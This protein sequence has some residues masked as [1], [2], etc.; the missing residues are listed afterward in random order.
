M[1]Q[2]PG[3]GRARLWVRVTVRVTGTPATSGTGCRPPSSGVPP[4]AA[5][6]SR[7]GSGAAPTWPFLLRSAGM[8]APGGFRSAAAAEPLLRPVLAAEATSWGLGSPRGGD[9]WDQP[10]PQ[11]GLAARGM[12]EMR[13]ALSALPG[14]RRPWDTGQVLG[15]HATFRRHLGSPGDMGAREDGGSLGAAETCPPHGGTTTTQTGPSNYF[16]HW[17]R[18][19]PRKQGPWF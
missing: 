5:G 2:R 15:A 12:A 9:F 10:G 17:E 14:D 4:R 13:C 6:C 19:F 8:G 7:W 18:R 1:E 11:E 16:T 3:V